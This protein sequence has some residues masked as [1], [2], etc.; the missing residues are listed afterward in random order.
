MSSGLYKWLCVEVITKTKIIHSLL[1]VFIAGFIP[2]G[3][4][5][6]IYGVT[7]REAMHTYLLVDE[8]TQNFGFKRMKYNIGHNANGLLKELVK[9][10]GLPEMIFEYENEG[11]NGIK[12][13]YVKLDRVTIFEYRSHWTSSSLYLKEYRP[14]DKYEKLMYEALINKA[15]PKQEG[16]T[17]TSRIMNF[18]THN[19]Q[20]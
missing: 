14:L 16:P 13:Y 6:I 1:L 15:K 2:T 9:R 17:V 19:P 18:S 7:M 10:V 4:S 5:S 3:C 20:L 11:K 12:M 8:A